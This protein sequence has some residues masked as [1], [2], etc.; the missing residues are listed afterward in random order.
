MRTVN[1]RLPMTAAVQSLD[2]TVLD[3]IKRSNIKLD[4]YKDV[5]RE[6]LAQGMQ[7][8][9]ELILC[10][11]GESKAT[12]MAGVRDLL[13]AGVTRISAHQLMLLE[14][15]P[16]NTQDNR[17]QFAFRTRFRVVARNIGEYLDERV[18]ETEEI[19][20]ETPDFT[21]DD[22][23]STRVF[24]LLLTIYYYEG[25]FEEAFELARQEGISA[26]DL[27]VRLQ[28]IVEE[29]PHVLGGLFKEFL[30]E[31][32]D[33]LF[34]TEGECRAWAE[35]HYLDLI[36]GTL[37]GNLLSKYSMSARFYHVGDA[38]ALLEDALSREL[39]RKGNGSRNAHVTAVGE[40]LRHVMLDAPF[41]RSLPST[42]SWTTRYDVDSW[43]RDGYAN[44][45][46]H[47]FG[48]EPVTYRAHVTS[49]QQTLIASRVE[50]FGEHPSGLGKFTRTLFSHDFR[51]QVENCI[52][53]HSRAEDRHA[54]T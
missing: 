52:T 10:L 9:G 27:V 22:Y 39:R 46:I 45:L 41:E 12:F 40:Y 19:V 43:R 24:H 30:R 21:F 44:R 49:A 29:S 6:V 18:V 31:S 34:D 20:V 54:S 16:L 50:T 33:E 32:K 8:Y 5:Q 47:Y 37:G 35:E 17:T 38:I 14:G 53:P 26:Y 15:A 7:S 36:D 11:P 42:P 25:N 23:L 2:P 4:T 1:G 28:S 48:P 51:R 3:N 13:D